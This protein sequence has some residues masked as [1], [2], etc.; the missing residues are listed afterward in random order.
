MKTTKEPNN[1]TINKGIA[2]STYSSS[3]KTNHK[4][5]IIID[6]F[7]DM[8]NILNDDQMIIA[9]YEHP[10]TTR[11]YLIRDHLTRDQY[12]K[13]DVHIH[14]GR[15]IGFRDAVEREFTRIKKIMADTT[16]VADNHR[17]RKLCICLRW[18]RRSSKEIKLTYRAIHAENGDIPL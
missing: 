11:D 4:R 1:Q 16:D 5:K 13:K 14:F 18:L 3:Q 8:E 9:G 2:M 6:H 7:Q 10:I 12:S 17:I 15:F